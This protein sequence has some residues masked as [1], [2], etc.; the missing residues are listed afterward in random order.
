VKLEKLV[1]VSEL[2]DRKP[3][4]LKG[5]G[6]NLCLV[7]SDSQVYAF[8]NRCPHTGARLDSGRV[9]RNVITCSH[10]LAQFDLLS[11]GVLSYPMEGL[12]PED[13]GA[14]TLYRVA[15]ADGWVTVDTDTIAGQ[16]AGDGR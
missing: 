11:G 9:R 7:L 4:R 16:A 2:Q 12:N 3:L 6:Y 10:H 8:M 5:E 14:L 15:I 13:T 1:H